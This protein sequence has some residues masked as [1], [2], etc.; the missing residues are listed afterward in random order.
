MIAESQTLEGTPLRFTK[1]GEGVYALV[2]GMPPGRRMTL[3]AIDGSR[4]RRV[5]LVGT[6]ELGSTGRSS[7]A[8][9]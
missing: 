9:A 6:D 8:A 1:S 7:A 3:R 2:M 4:V 5:R